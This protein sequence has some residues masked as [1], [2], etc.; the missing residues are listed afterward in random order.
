MVSTGGDVAVEYVDG[1]IMTMPELIPGVQYG[2]LIV[3]VLA[4]GTDATGIKGLV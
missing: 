2:G 1:S 3:K 4:T